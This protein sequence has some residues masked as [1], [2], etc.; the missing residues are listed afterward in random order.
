MRRGVEPIDSGSCRTPPPH[1]PEVNEA[2]ASRGVGLTR[3]DA[4]V[5]FRAFGEGRLH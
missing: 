5:E 4:H 3:G 2:A 1:N